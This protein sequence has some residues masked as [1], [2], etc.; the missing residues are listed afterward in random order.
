MSP[1]SRIKKGLVQAGL[2]SSTESPPEDLDFLQL[3]GTLGPA[4]DGP[5]LR[6]DLVEFEMR[7]LK[8]HVDKLKFN[9]LEMSTKQQFMQRLL[10][11]DEWSHLCNNAIWTPADIK[12]LGMAPPRVPA[13]QPGV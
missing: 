2:Q 4:T 8:E 5:R 11:P 12:S 13:L 9:F 10:D 7:H 1:P 3:T 6:L